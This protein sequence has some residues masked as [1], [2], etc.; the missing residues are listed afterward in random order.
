MISKIL[1]GSALTVIITGRADPFVINRDHKLFDS[2]LQAVN[3]RDEKKVLELI[4]IVN[5]VQEF[6][7]GKV[8]IKHG[9]VFVDGEA[10]HNLIADRILEAYEL[11]LDFSDMA[12]FLSNLMANPSYQSRQELYPFLESGNMPITEDGRF[13][14]Y[15][16]VRS[17][18]TDCHTGKINNSPGQVV[19][20]DRGKVDDDRNV[21]CSSGLHVCTH[22]YTRFGDRL[23]IVAVNPKDVVSVPSDYNDSKLRCCEYE[24]LYE[25]STDE[26]KKFET[27]FANTQPRDASG[28][29]VKRA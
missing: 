11:T 26:F 8:T 27:G 15:K 5:T 12:L 20:M 29:F 19:K 2:I 3:S 23:M 6:T 4:D 24:V 21:T 25:V 28:R 1:T 14:A 10:V 16:W 22:G 7:E 9:Q 17:D 13:L 18:Y